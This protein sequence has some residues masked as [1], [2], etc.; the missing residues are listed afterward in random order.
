ML[1]EDTVGSL[2]GISLPWWKG[3]RILCA[4]VLSWRSM[5]SMASRQQG[6]ARARQSQLRGRQGLKMRAWATFKAQR[7]CGFVLCSL[8]G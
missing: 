2:Q 6:P 3:T 4:R 1:T 8:K 7:G 5:A